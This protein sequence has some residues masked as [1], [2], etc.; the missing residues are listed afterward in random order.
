MIVDCRNIAWNIVSVVVRQP[1]HYAPCESN[2]VC[3]TVQ[4]SILWHVVIWCKSLESE[5]DFCAI[6]RVPSHQI[7]GAVID[8]SSTIDV[9][10][11]VKSSHLPTNI[12]HLCFVMLGQRITAK[13]LLICD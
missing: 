7:S 3:S 9:C 1:Q 12:L 4:C 11:S 5:G 6:P 2:V 8:V 13:R 10:F